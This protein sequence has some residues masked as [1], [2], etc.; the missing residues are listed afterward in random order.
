MVHALQETHEQL[1]ECLSAT[2]RHVDI[3]SSNLEPVLLSDAAISSAL[4]NLARRGPHTRIRLLASNLSAQ[5]I[6]SHPLLLLA[7]RLTTAIEL[8]LLT[9]HPEWP[10]ATWIVCDQSDG[11]LLSTRNKL[12]RRLQRAEAKAMAGRFERLWQ[13]AIPSPEMRQF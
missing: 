2:A 6:A 3:I 9:E 5:E 4:T 8:R 7:K 12:S 10:E 1:L 13:A 11:V